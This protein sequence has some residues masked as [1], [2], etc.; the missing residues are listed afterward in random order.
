MSE[1]SA[2]FRLGAVF[3]P[4]PA[5]LIGFTINVSNIKALEERLASGKIAHKTR[6]N[7]IVI[8]SDNAFGV[9]IAFEQ[10]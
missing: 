9:S 8:P 2:A 6:S 3:N 7:S 1:A 10:A 5:R 4:I